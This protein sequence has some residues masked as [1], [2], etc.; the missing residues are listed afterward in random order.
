[1]DPKKIMEAAV[2]AAQAH[3]RQM[4]KTG[5]E[6]YINHLLR[7]ANGAISA[8]LSEDAVIASLLHDAVEDTHITREDLSQH[9]SPRVVEL[10][11]LLTQ[12]WDDH[13]SQEIKK[14]EKPKY[15]SAILRDSEAINIKLLDRADNLN[16]MTR[17]LPNARSWAEKYLRRSLEE[18]G[19]LAEA[20]DNPQCRAIFEKAVDDL[21]AALHSRSR[22]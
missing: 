1:M 19:P 22:R 4:R 3:A 21:R 6:P 7:V 16:D 10:V 17:M 18:V 5:H 2:F 20:A 8:G 11:H 15:Y 14:S 9:F 12:W 13:A